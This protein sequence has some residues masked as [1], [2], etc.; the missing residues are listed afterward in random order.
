M[1]IIR[2]CAELRNNYNEIS[3]ICHE[4]QE[5]VYITKNGTNDLVI[6]SNEA[7]EKSEDIKI[8]N[9][10]EEIFNKKYSDFEAFKNEIY[11]KINT[12]LKQI[13]EGKYVSAKQAFKELEEKYEL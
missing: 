1:A 11:E 8:T 13:E 3:R 5:P 9:K 12:G 2:P 10:V 4:T 7:Y 6:L